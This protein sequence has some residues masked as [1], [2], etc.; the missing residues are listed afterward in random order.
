MFQG[1]HVL[2]PQAHVLRPVTG[3]A[4]LAPAQ[5]PDVADI[6]VHAWELH[7]ADQTP[8]VDRLGLGM[9]Q[10]VAQ[11]QCLHHA[12]LVLAQ[13]A[14]ALGGGK[15]TPDRGRQQVTGDLLAAQARQIPGLQLGFVRPQARFCPSALD[16]KC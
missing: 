9:E 8:A 14:V 4:V 15:P 13:A 3:L 10:T 2:T 6:D 5:Q 11:A 12:G 1:T 7:F 16:W